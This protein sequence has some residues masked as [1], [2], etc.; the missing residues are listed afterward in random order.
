MLGHRAAV[1]LS[2]IGRFTLHTPFAHHS[3]AICAIR[4]KLNAQTLKAWSKAAK[5]VF[6]IP[7]TS[8]ASERV[9]ALLKNMFG[10]NQILSLG[11]YIEAALMLAYNE[12]KVG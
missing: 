3:F 6:A 4:C 1:E 10:D 9:F 8:A 2:I 11:D 12:R 7:P 5:I